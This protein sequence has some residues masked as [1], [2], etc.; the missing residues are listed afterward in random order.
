MKAKPRHFKCIWVPSSAENCSAATEFL[1]EAG[2]QMRIYILV[3][4]SVADIQGWNS[5]LEAAQAILAL[6]Q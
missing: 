2:T 6:Q 1:R 4:S 5:P 3:T